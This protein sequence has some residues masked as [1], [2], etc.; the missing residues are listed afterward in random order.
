[1]FADTFE[2]NEDY[3]PEKNINK[4]Q[5]L[6]VDDEIF[7]IEA[8]KVILEH[9]FDISNVDSICEIAMNG[10][11]S[12]LKVMNNVSKNNDA[13]CNYDLILMD[14]NMPIL[15]GYEATS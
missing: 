5:I 13:Y 1:M 3:E 4:R 7:N 15:D 6:I 14:C 9:R 11:E 8:I 2:F 12:V 10:Q